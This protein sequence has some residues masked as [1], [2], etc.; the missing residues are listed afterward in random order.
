[1]EPVLLERLHR[2]E[3]IGELFDS[4]VRET[5]GDAVFDGFIK[6]QPGY[7]LPDKFAMFSQEGNRL[8]KEALAWFLP[9]AREAAER[10]GRDTFP[11]RLAAFQDLEVRTERQN[12]NNDFFGWFDP[13][14]FDEAGN[15]I[16]R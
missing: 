14:Q 9:A 3:A 15:V 16:R 12:D 5:M 10:D 1:M 2:L 7:V 6:P 13:E 11:K 8:V 4:A